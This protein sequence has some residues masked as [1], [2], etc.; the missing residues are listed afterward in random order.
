MDNL[1]QYLGT[2]AHSGSFN[3]NLDERLAR[4]VAQGVRPATLRF[5]QW[6]PYCISLGKHQK[7][8]EIDTTR[9]K[10]EGIDVVFRPTGGRAILH[11]EELTYS[12][13]FS[14]QNAGSIDET[15]CQISRAIVA[16]LRALGVPA[17]MTSVQP[18]FKSL[19]REPS[20]VICF[21]N[22][23]KYEIQVKGKKLV[24]SAQR[25]I[26]GA[27]L[28]HGSILIGPDH[29]RL[30]EFLN[31][32][33]EEKLRMQGLMKEKTIE[34]TRIKK[35]GL[36]ELKGSLLESFRENFKFRV[37]NFNELKFSH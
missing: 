3:M 19:Y 7:L 37:S 5:F 13:V 9:C 18:D 11:A 17:E 14:D 1:W 4:E 27:V 12:V 30:A 2:G 23:A 20:S 22:S 33:D 21:S 6:Q 10:A 15:Y 26:A 24:G 32:S 8:D 16:G 35:I 29:R 28:Q 36:D 31:I 34:I 25:R